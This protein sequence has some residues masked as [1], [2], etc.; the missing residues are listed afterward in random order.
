MGLALQIFVPVLHGWP[1]YSCTNRDVGIRHEAGSQE[2]RQKNDIHRVNVLWLSGGL[3]LDAFQ[4]AKIANLRAGGAHV[5]HSE[6]K[7]M[8]ETS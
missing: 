2:P 1:C 4:R 7:T 6:H 8:L 3:T 5:A